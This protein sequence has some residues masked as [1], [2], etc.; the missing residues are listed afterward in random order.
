MQLKFVAAKHRHQP[1]R[2]RATKVRSR[3]TQM[4]ANKCKR[5]FH[6]K[7]K[8]AACARTALARGGRRRSLPPAGEQQQAAVLRTS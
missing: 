6:T 1:I 7:A 2:Q 5:S 4:P 8:L 3:P